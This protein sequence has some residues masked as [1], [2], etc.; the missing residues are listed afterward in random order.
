MQMTVATET[1]RY[2]IYIFWNNR[3]LG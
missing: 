3:K 1:K 2:P